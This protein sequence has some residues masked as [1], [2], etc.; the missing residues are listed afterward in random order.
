ML[1]KFNTIYTLTLI[2]MEILVL[3]CKNETRLK[4]KAGKWLTKMPTD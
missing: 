1:Q 3:F 2:A 4:W